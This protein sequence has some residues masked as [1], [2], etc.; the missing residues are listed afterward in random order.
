MGSK[1]GL[2]WKMVGEQL[3]VSIPKAV[4][5]NPPC[6]HAWTIRISAVQ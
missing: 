2:T 1:A 6:Q 4:R 3:T 5:E